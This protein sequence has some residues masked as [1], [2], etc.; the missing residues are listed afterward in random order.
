[1]GYTGDGIGGGGGGGTVER[2]ICLWEG[3]DEENI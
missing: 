3:E 1:M 2:K